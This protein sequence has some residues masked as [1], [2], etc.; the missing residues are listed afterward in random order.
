[1]TIILFCIRIT[2]AETLAA[3]HHVQC[4]YQWGDDSTVADV[5][6]ALRI[7]SLDKIVTH[8]GDAAKVERD[9][10][11]NEREPDFLLSANPS[12]PASDTRNNVVGLIVTMALTH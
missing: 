12:K 1:M 8:G 4:F 6:N 2:H 9:H 3:V 10:K 11:G 7:Q 5:F